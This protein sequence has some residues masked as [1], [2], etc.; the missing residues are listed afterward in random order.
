MVKHANGFLILAVGMLAVFLFSCDPKKKYQTEI[1]KIDSTLLNLEEAQSRYA[2][3]PFDSIAGFYA[4]VKLE[5]KLVTEKYTGEMDKD[6]AF[7]LSQYRDIPNFV[8]N[9]PE[10]YSSIGKELEKSKNQL[11]N[12]KSALE[13]GAGKDQ[14]GN[15]IDKSYAEKYTAEECRI[16]GQVVEQITK[17]ETRFPESVERYNTLYPQLEAFF[18]SLRTIPAADSG[19]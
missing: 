5:M 3:I 4:K 18:D 17:I 13:S 15:S 1:A 8:K 16:A 10:V 19:L 7:I 11:V 2:K 12:L 9:F 14:M 6:R